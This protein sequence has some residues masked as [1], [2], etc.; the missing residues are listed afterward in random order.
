VIGV[1]G[2]VFDILCLLLSRAVA[3]ENKQLAKG[4]PEKGKP[5]KAR[6]RWFFNHRK[7][8]NKKT[9]KNQLIKLH[10]MSDRKLRDVAENTYKSNA[11]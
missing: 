5:H 11:R 9:D 10:F 4:K 8:A 7:S 2:L 6:N 1:L 3:R